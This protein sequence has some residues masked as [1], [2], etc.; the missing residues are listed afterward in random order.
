MSVA[1]DWPLYALLT[2][3]LISPALDLLGHAKG[4]K[5][6]PNVYLVFSSG[7]GLALTTAIFT[8]HVFWDEASWPFVVSYGPLGVGTCFL[9]D[10]ASLFLIS[11][12][13]LLIFIS[14]I[15]SLGR[16]PF[17]PGF[18]VAL[19]ALA[20]GMV[21][22]LCSGDLLTF[23]VFWEI[24]CLAAYALVFMGE[25]R[26]ALEAAWKYF[27]MGSVGAIVMLFAIALL[28]GMAGTLNMPLLAQRLSSTKSP[29]LNIALVLFISG[30]GVEAALF[31]LH[32]WLPDA[33]SEA[34]TPV[35]SVLAGITTEI[36]FYGLLRTSITVF[37][38]SSTLWRSILAVICL[39]NM[40]L[41][42]LCALVQTDVKRFLA[43]S[44]LAVIGYA[45][46]ALV[47]SSQDALS[48]VLFLILSHALSKGLAFLCAGS[49]SSAAGSRDVSS[50]G[51]MKARLPSIL[52]AFFLSLVCRA[53]LPGTSGFIE[54]LVLISALFAAPSWWWLA[55]F[56]VLNTVIAAGA[57]F[58]IMWIILKR[59]RGLNESAE[60]EKNWP[61]ILSTIVLSFF[62][63]A[64]G[65]W[66]T[67]ALELAKLG[68]HDLVDIRGYAR[69][70]GGG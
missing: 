31:P 67:P 20:L 48:A 22:V 19:S 25:R 18:C 60:V 27:I 10:R 39:A 12:A 54:K 46:A 26:E 51:A 36:G 4:L 55:L 57:C 23:Y 30:A 3:L 44:S 50:I 5:Y 14:A 65:I 62:V 43:Y 70:V 17:Q 47:V 40:F 64:L 66:P 29:W 21:G 61:E 2:S 6:L 59:S 11:T 28:Y 58:R 49:L 68:A 33:Y 38:G 63:I 16:G 13:L 53:G 24:M 15:H 37:Q 8:S 34:P 9:V 32:T 45:L 35:S 7:L 69:A 41:G 42:N 1:P 52:A 56:L